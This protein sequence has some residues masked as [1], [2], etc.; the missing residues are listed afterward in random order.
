MKKIINFQLIIHI[1]FCIIL[2]FWFI[3]YSTIRPS[4]FP[5]L[6]KEVIS[7][8]I[9]LTALYINL[10][11]LIPKLYYRNYKLFYILLS[12]FLICLSGA[13][14]MWMVE[15]N[16]SKCV[17]AAF[18]D[19]DYNH[20]IMHTSIMVTL[21]NG[22]FYLFFT[23]L[24]FHYYTKKNT[25]REKISIGKKKGIMSFIRCNNKDLVIDIDKIIY[26]QQKGNRT[27]IHTTSGKCFLVYNSLNL[28]E[29]YSD[30]LVRINRNAIVN[31]N[32]I[33]SFTQNHLHI[34]ES[35]HGKLVSLDYFKNNHSSIYLILQKTVPHL[36]KKNATILPQ[37]GFFEN[38]FDEKNDE[39][40]K[41]VIVKAKILKEIK[42][43]P[44]INAIKLHKNLQTK[45]SIRTIKRR[46][47]EL[48]DSGLIQFQG[49]DK[50]GGYYIV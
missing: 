43:N 2:P 40:N 35:K 33:I 18:S 13:T 8:I 44:G 30:I 21:R 47:K 39:N 49:A 22:G 11:I 4:S 14:E 28:I 19:R 29:K 20:Y 50:T 24:G 12:L 23:V 10:F 34:K 15:S 7:A 16:I 48:T 38:V 42:Q 1:L 31:Y 45:T 6:Y 17:R 46:L 27:T 9:L 25:L 26:F 36:E 5:H 32:K 37:N 41:I 3:Y